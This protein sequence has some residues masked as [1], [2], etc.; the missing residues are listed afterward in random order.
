MIFPKKDIIANVVLGAL[1]ANFKG[2][3]ISNVNISETVRASAK[4]PDMSFIDFDI[5]HR[6]T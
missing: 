3:Q 6:M 2:K 5:C 4:M 1:D